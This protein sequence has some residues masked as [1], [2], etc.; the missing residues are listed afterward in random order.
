MICAKT[1]AH[2]GF[3]VFA[4]PTKYPINAMRRL[5][6]GRADCESGF[7]EL[8]NQFGMSGFTTQEISRG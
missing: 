7:A 1:I 6:R 2:A 3:T 5:S 4:G 8:K